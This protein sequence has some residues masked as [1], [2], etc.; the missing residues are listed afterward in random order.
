[1]HRTHIMHPTLPALPCTHSYGSYP[2][3]LQHSAVF[4]GLFAVARRFY[5][6]FQ[7]HC[8]YDNAAAIS[9]TLAGG[10]QSSC[11]SYST[12]RNVGPDA[13]LMCPDTR[14]ERSIHQVRCGCL[15]RV[16][17]SMRG[18]HPWSV[19]AST[20]ACLNSCPGPG[21]TPQCR[22]A[23]AHPAT[24]QHARRTPATNTHPALVQ[25]LPPGGWDMLFGEVTRRLAARPPGTV[26]HLLVLLP[27]PIVYRE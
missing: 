20:L 7:H 16:Q 18:W 24:Q 8:R 13:I 25:V 27:V 4:Q 26:N 11:Y 12:V 1:M 23:G 21:S 14:S 5:L 3:Y 2:D 10:P 6:L 22:G 9:K 19:S 15:S 17:T